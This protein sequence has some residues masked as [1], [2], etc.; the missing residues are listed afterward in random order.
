MTESNIKGSFRG[1]G[2]VPLNPENMIS[3]LNVKLRT[4]TPIKEEA[5]ASTS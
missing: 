3:K 1:A 4:P 2:L 5:S